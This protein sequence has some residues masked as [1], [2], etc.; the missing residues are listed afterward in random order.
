MHHAP[1]PRAQP[2]DRETA[3]QRH[4]KSRESL[5]KTLAPGPDP[6]P[7]QSQC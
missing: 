3:E 4:R 1:S 5:L 7:A 2:L 6:T